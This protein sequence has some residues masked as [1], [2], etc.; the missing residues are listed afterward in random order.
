M[1]GNTVEESAKIFSKILRREGSWAQNAVVLA[2]AAMSLHCTG[3]I[4]IMTMLMQWL[5]KAWK[6]EELTSRLKN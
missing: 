2:N 3:D 1:G 6:V 4:R 5:L